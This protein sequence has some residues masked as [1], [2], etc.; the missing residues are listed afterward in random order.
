MRRTSNELREFQQDMSE[1]TSIKREDG[2]IVLTTGYNPCIYSWYVLPNYTD[3]TDFQ[4]PSMHCR[5]AFEPSG[6]DS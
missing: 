1:S 6:N 3:V 2:G 4:E 5:H